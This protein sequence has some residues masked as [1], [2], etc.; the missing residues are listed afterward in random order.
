MYL[1]TRPTTGELMENYQILKNRLSDHK[2][3]TFT[4]ETM[5]KRLLIDRTKFLRK[6]G[7]YKF[8]AM[9]MSDGKV[10]LWVL[11]LYYDD[12]MQLLKCIEPGEPVGAEDFEKIYAIANNWLN[13]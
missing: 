3:I 10:H 6:G 2:Y 7:K 13:S 9:R 12:N 11:D 1:L 8:K 5:P 4:G